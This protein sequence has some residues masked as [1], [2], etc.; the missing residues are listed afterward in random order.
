MSIT[1]K[2]RTY[3]T[4]FFKE[5][6]SIS[7]YYIFGSSTNKSNTLNSDFS[8]NEFLENT[9]FGKKVDPSDVF[10]MINNNRWQFGQIYD[11]Y[12]DKVD[13]S[14]KTYYVIVY[15]SDNSTGDYRVF[16]CIFNNYGSESFNAPNYTPDTD[17]QIYRMGD[18]YIWKYMYAISTIEFQKYTSAGFAPIIGTSSANTIIGRSIDHIEVENNEINQGYELREGIIEEVFNDD[19]VIYSNNLNLSEIANYY[20][21]QNFNVINPDNEARTYTIDTY[22]FDTASKRATIKLLDKDLFID[23]NFTFKI[24]PRI[25]ITGDGTGARAIP[26]INQ[27]GTIEKI[28]VLNKG[29]GYTRATARVVTPLF[30]FDTTTE[31]STD[32]EAILRP[33]L[34]PEGGHAT[35]FP[36]ELQSKRS[37][38]YLTLTNTDN[39]SIPSTNVYTKLGL[40]KNPEFTSNTTPELFDNRIQLELSADILTENEIVTQT[41]NNNVTFSAQVHE[42][43]DSA[44]YLCNYHG[45]YP[46]YGEEDD[47]Y[48]DIPIQTNRPIISSQGQ[49]LSINNII[50]PPY[51]QKT[52]D[53]YYMTSFS[54][55]TR[56]SSSNEEYKIILEF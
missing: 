6:F 14:E 34:S 53:V 28:L 7:D 33:I 48:I 4:N 31:I 25:E 54:P 10:F 23:E 51:I 55:I 29:S 38:V 35:N 39:L 16:K 18:G 47:G 8:V 30:G 44:V 32:V 17:D 24:F 12:D 27:F 19:I 41:D 36:N 50:R 37:L 1:N 13:L 22:S 46:N 26:I 42:V 45:P 40:V 3:N 43:K 56:T 2:F 49:V 15:P 52:G 21:G 9:L 11:Q 5:D 20:T